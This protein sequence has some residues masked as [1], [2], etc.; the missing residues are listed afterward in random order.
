[1]TSPQQLAA[2]H[3][4]T[5]KIV[6]LSVDRIEPHP[7]NVR[8]DLGDDLGDLA[9]SIRRHGILQPLTVQPHP[10]K[11]NRYRILA[12]H[13]RFDAAQLAGLTAVPVVIRHGVTDEGA[14]ELML[15]ENCQRR[16]LG[17]M[18]RAEALG[19]LVNRGYTHQRIA[20]QTGKSVSWV[21][22]YLA[23]L[24]LDEASQ[25][26]VRAGELAV[27]HAINGVRRARA[28]TRKKRGSTA[29]F[30][31]EPDHLS[32][33]HPQAKA[34]A[35]FC[36]ARGHTMRRRIGDVACGQCWESAIRLDERKVIE[37]EEAM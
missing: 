3:T 16:E 20:E 33:T 25:E 26:K 5:Q 12:G 23:L 32:R 28:K 30:T 27:K 15:V 6:V 31:W 35:R 29:D 21:G 14:L 19:A 10:H 9:R 22:Y 24:D 7:A 11:S 4:L 36:D 8:E 18:E 2:A 17:A 34:A 1:M 37:A 13:R